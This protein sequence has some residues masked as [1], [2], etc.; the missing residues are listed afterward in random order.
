[1][2]QVKG[3]GGW[4]DKPFRRNGGIFWIF[5]SQQLTLFYHDQ[6]DTLCQISKQMQ[7]ASVCRWGVSLTWKRQICL[8]GT[9]NFLPASAAVLSARGE[10]AGPMQDKTCHVRGDRRGPGF[11][12]TIH[13]VWR[14]TE[15]VSERQDIREQKR[16]LR[17]FEALNQFFWGKREKEEGRQ[18]RKRQKRIQEKDKVN[19]VLGSAAHSSGS[20]H[21]RDFVCK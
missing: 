12:F 5:F 19:Q 1:M 20:E 3:W 14:A 2:S 4:T 11:V 13:S 9:C 21:L 6:K 15:G 16:S 10:H 7:T 8:S 17:R 18:R